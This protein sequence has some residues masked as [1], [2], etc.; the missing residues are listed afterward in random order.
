MGDTG[1]QLCAELAEDSGLGAGDLMAGTDTALLDPIELFWPPPIEEEGR[2]LGGGGAAAS[3]AAK[4]S[5]SS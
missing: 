1:L 2:D 5:S 3:N 4:K